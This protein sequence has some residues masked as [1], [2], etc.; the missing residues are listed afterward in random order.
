MCDCAVCLLV[1]I[2]LNLELLPQPPVLT[3]FTESIH[4]YAIVILM[5]RSKY[6]TSFELF[7][8]IISVSKNSPFYNDFV[9]KFLGAK[10]NSTR[11]MD[12]KNI[13]PVW[14]NGA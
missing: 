10:G 9:K 5:S 8:D 3:F 1:S 6:F 14:R 11:Y 4:L 7:H 13:S 2:W 12:P